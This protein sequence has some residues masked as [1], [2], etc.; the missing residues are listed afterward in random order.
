MSAKIA[1]FSGERTEL[2]PRG[3]SSSVNALM[4]NPENPSDMEAAVLSVQRSVTYTN[5][6]SGP[7]R[8]PVLSSG[9][10]G[11]RRGRAL[12]RSWK[13]AA[14]GQELAGAV[15]AGEKGREGSH[16]T[17]KGSVHG[18]TGQNGEGKEDAGPRTSRTYRCDGKTLCAQGQGY[19][20]PAL[21]RVLAYAV[22]RYHNLNAHAEEDK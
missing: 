4:G 14:G 7:D 2:L 12:T 22:P 21:S 15:R 19:G 8:V 5:Y 1:A 9:A 11:L 18:L 10:Q 17:R 20:R 13:E 3:Q 6:N 16:L